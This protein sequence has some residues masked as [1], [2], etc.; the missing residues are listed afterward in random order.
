MFLSFSSI[1]DGGLLKKEHHFFTKS[2]KI[3]MMI[4]WDNLKKLLL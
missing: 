1:A 3:G 4:E 2:R